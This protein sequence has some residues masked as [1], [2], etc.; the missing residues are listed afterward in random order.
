ME[1]GFV[2]PLGPT[3]VHPYLITHITLYNFIFIQT[4]Q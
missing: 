4:K 2:P 1:L 3:W